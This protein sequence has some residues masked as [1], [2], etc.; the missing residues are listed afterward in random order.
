[1]E[2]YCHYYKVPLF[3]PK[4]AI[5]MVLSQV[6]LRRKLL[7]VYEREDKIIINLIID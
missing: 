5:K 7:A 6:L 2:A 4:I 1:M 3:V